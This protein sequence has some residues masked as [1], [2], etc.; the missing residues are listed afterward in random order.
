MFKSSTKLENFMSAS[1]EF[2]I[3]IEKEKHN[4]KR[5]WK[6]DLLENVIKPE[7]EELLNYA[8]K[9][10]IYFKY[11]RKQRLLE[12]IYFINDTLEPFGNT[13]LGDKIYKLHA[14]YRFL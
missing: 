2:L 10:K 3:E 5:I 7:I 9:G 6:Y 14:I 8:L 12:S 1:Q 13:L 11:G 4:S